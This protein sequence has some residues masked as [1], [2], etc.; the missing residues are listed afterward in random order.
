MQLTFYEIFKE[1]S[2]QD[3]EEKMVE[4]LYK[5][6]SAEMKFVLGY[7]FDPNIKWNLPDGAPPYKE[8]PEGIEND[9]RLMNELRRLYLFVEGPTEEQQNLTTVRRELLFIEILESL[10]PNEAKF[11][12]AMKDKKLPFDNITK[13]VISKA[14]PK[15]ASNW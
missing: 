4:A 8:C 6:S 13:D 5:H 3:T 12:L 11:L 9:G 14:F 1:V 7:I 2:E 10:S 15:L